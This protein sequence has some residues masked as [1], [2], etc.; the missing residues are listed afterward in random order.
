MF[1]ASHE[2]GHAPGAGMTRYWLIDGGVVTQAEWQQVDA[3]TSTCH[4]YEFLNDEQATLMGPRVL[5][6]TSD[7]RQLTDALKADEIRRWA[8]SELHTDL[9]HEALAVHLKKLVYCWTAD[10]QRF[11]LRFADGRSMRAFWSVLSD[12]QRGNIA[13]PLSAWQTTERDGKAVDLMPPHKP[14]HAS[15][16]SFR[17]TLSDAQLSGLMEASWPDQLLS[18]VLDEQ[19]H[20]AGMCSA[21]ARY[22]LAV[23]TCSWLKERG[24]ERYPQQ[25]AALAHVLT[26]S[27][28]TW[29]EPQSQEAA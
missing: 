20:L 23:R 7:S 27:H 12:K 17:L 9:G 14:N 13:G 19:P 1:H 28:G 4:L 26:H 15:H 22:E 3:H 10:G 25:K 6:D 5:S 2:R 16:P 24:E 21:T 8:V 18:A 11:F 29:I